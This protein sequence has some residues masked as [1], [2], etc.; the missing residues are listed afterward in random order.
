MWFSKKSNF[1]FNFQIENKN[2]RKESD[3]DGG[4]RVFIF[5]SVSLFTSEFPDTPDLDIKKTHHFPS[6][7]LPIQIRTSINQNEHFHY[8]LSEAY[9]KC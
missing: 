9:P 1:F 6:M 2:N 8:D 5:V 7:V 4:Q 3:E